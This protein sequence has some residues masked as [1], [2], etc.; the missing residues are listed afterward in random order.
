MDNLDLLKEK[1]QSV[2]QELPKLSYSDIYQM[3]LKKSSSILKWIVIISICEITFWTL[4]SL[5]VPESSKQFYSDMGVQNFI[6][7]VN[8]INYFVVAIFIYMFYKNHKKIKATQSVKTLMGNI[9]RARK[10]VH[11]FVFY[12]I[13]LA[14][15]LVFGLNTYYYFHTEELNSVLKKDELYSAYPAETFIGA[16]IFAGILVLV[17]LVLFYWV[18][19]G[20]L[21]KHLKRNYNELRKIEA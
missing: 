14:T 12:N 6:K 17:F 11:Y 20:I 13:G 10:T 15:L 7:W 8:I 16:N 2:E 19:Y 3:L 9:L 1:W 18:A 5:F 21:L 4:L